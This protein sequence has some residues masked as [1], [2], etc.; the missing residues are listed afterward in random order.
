[1]LAWYPTGMTLAILACAHQVQDFLHNT[2]SGM[3][4]LSTYI[5][6]HILIGSLYVMKVI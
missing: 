4:R 6:V 2:H 1:M 5:S 3:S